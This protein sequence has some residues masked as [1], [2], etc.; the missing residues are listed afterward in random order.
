MPQAEQPPARALQWPPGGGRAPVAVSGARGHIDA[1]PGQAARP[2]VEAPTSIYRQRPP[3]PALAGQVLCL[4][5]QV[6]GAGTTG[7][8][9]RVLPDGCIDIV[10]IGDAPAVVA[11]P[12]TGPVVVPLAPRSTVVG[13]RL[14]PGAAPGLLGAPASELL[15]R[16]TPL[17]ELWGAAGDALSAQVVAQPALAAKLNAAAAEFAPHLAGAGPPD[18]MIAAATLWLAR[19]PAG[20]IADLCRLLEVGERRLRRRF[21]AA[22][23]YGPKT[24]QRVLRLQRVLAQAGRLPRAGASLAALA[25]EAGYADQAHMSRE[26]QALTGRSPAALLQR[27]ASTLELSGLFKT[28]SDGAA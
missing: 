9:H 23:G 17:G 13:L 11:G 28:A 8:C 5:S 12:A 19:H 26:L 10:W 15:N 2:T 22:I 4:W 1:M 16:D 6:I 20:R 7:L 14:R 27:A 18:P 21:A 25:A 3:P 24:F